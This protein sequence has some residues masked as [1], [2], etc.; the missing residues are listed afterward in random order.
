[1]NRNGGSHGAHP[2]GGGRG[3]AVNRPKRSREDIDSTPAAGF[4]PG[5]F[6]VDEKEYIAK[7]LAQYVAEDKIDSRPGPGGRKIAYLSSWRALSEANEIFSPFAWSTTIKS[8][9]LDYQDFDPQK[10]RH[11]AAY[12]AIVRV[13]LLNGCFHEDVGCGDHENPSRATAHAHAKKE[14]VSDGTKRALRQFGNALGNSLYDKTY[15]AKVQAKG[16]QL[17]PGPGQDRTTFEEF[18][19]RKQKRQRLEE[20]NQADSTSSGQTFH[21]KAE[22]QQT[23]ATEVN[24]STWGVAGA[25]HGVTPPQNHSE[26]QQRPQPP[27]SHTTPQAQQSSSA[28]ASQSQPNRL[29]PTTQSLSQ[30]APYRGW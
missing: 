8:L 29:G 16:P 11:I 15:L 21:F 24:A 13:T 4:G 26:A 2:P 22:P 12:S 19:R 5:A 6:T 17:A 10:R 20:Q 1:M 9:N 18:L 27:M 14:A 3:G 7:E 30:P 28:P 23:K 25:Q